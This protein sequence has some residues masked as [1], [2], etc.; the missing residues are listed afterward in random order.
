M[1]NDRPPLPNARTVPFAVRLRRARHAAG[2]TQEA[3]AERAGLTPNS[4]SALERGEH[5]HPYPA[6]VRALAA[7]LGMSEEEQAALLASVPRRGQPVPAASSASLAVPIPLVPL[8][9]RHVAI[10]ELLALLRREEVRLVTLTG[11][12]GVGKTSLALHVAD[13][14]AG[15]FDDGAVFVALASVRDASLVPAA[16]ADALGVTETGNRSLAD[17][18]A[19]ALGDRHLLL[20]LDNFEHLLPAASLITQLLAR[21]RNLVVL[22]TSRAPLR[23]AGEH[24]LPVPPLALPGA[25]DVDTA[26]EVAG[27]PAVQLFV[28]R[29]HEADPA[30]SLH[31]DNAAALAAICRR[32]DGLPLAI[33]LA[34]ARSRFL[35]PPAL[36]PRL[37][38][39]LP[40][41]TGGRRDAPDRHRTMREAIG[42]SYDILGAGEQRLF[43]RL[44]VFVGGFTLDAATAV[45]CPADD[46]LEHLSTLVEHRLV[47][48]IPSPLKEPRFMMLETIREFALEQLAESGEATATEAAHTAWCRQLLERA[49]PFWFSPAQADWADRLD[50]EHDNLR[51]AL[52][53]SA[54]TAG[55]TA[56]VHLAGRL[57]PYW[58][59]R[60]HISEGRRWLTRWVE[61]TSGDH[62][63]ERVRVLTGAA[64]LA[65]VQGDEAPATIWGREALA[66]AE[67]IGAGTGI[68]AAHVLI[69]LGIAASIREDFDEAIAQYETALTVLRGLTATEPSA[70]P[71]ASVLLI[72]MASIALSHGD[73]ERATQLAEEALSH[74]R[75]HDFSWGAAES[76]SL[77]ALVAR[78][79]NDPVRAVS[80]FRESLTLAQD[81]QDPVQLVF[82]LDH[83]ARSI[84]QISV[85][86]DVVRIV[87][88]V[89]AFADRIG[90]YTDPATLADRQHDLDI[91]ESCLGPVVYRDAL[92][93]GH[94]LSI[95][96]AIDRALA[97]ASHLLSNNDAGG[98][99]IRL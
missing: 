48:R 89:M 95:D 37:E 34:A 57:W 77:L 99:S 71:V 75:R 49:G 70:A 33:E 26:A 29:A 66:I 60:G 55:D 22:V 19:G 4:I 73:D 5:R 8:I 98:E 97:L 78:H 64:A 43:R 32:L 79:R 42:W 30:F 91:L 36:L 53:R 59:I 38:R 74:Q 20:V 50:A 84:G 16:V 80:L 63:I 6:T 13:E 87:S 72:N 35:P 9:G 76:T 61:R 15:A 47:D 12:G 68:D 24:V 39:R 21:C 93:E 7:A 3:L 92:A 17:E 67:T 83:L 52:A 54:G 85:Q 94:L 81:Q 2:L 82:A 96:E 44:S 46:V 65:Q 62:T 27:V 28:E 40:L 10:T 14:I 41:L 45:A 31:D 11:A 18:V 25:T 1:G 86:R 69:G 90:L 88:A 58:F 51:A 23:L 56:G